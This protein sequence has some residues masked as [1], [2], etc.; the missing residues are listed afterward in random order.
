MLASTLR[1]ASTAAVRRCTSSSSAAALAIRAYSSADSDFNY[2]QHKKVA[3]TG[4]RFEQTDLAQQPNPTPA[5][6]L[7]AQEPVRK[8][9]THCGPLGHPK[10]YINLDQ[11]GPHKCLYCGVRFEQEHGHHH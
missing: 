10:V 8:V 5:I 2:Y 7:I 6:D 9:N 1:A 11:E 4:P 3:M